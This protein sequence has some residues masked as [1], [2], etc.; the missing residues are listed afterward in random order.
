TEFSGQP[1]TP[2]LLAFLMPQFAELIPP[3]TAEVEIR[4]RPTAAPYL[5]GNAG[6]NGEPGELALSNLQLDF[7][8]TAYLLND[9]TL[10]ENAEGFKWLS[11]A[12]DT[13][14]GFDL[15]W[16]AASSSLKP[17]LTPPPPSAV[18]ARV[19][20]NQIQTSELPT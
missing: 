13:A 12:I 15:V 17:T 19:V 9:G 2:A 7:V 5:T 11:I 6:P 1:L 8:Q 16:D 18:R 4:V 3:G 20:F 10:V 14:F